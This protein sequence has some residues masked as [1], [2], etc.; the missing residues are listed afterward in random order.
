[1]YKT[2]SW[3]IIKA[4]IFYAVL[5]VGWSFCVSTYVGVV[6][7]IANKELQIMGVSDMTKLGPSLDPNFEVA[8]YHRDAAAM[9]DSLFDFKLESLRSHIPMF[10]ALTFAIPYSF[11]RRLKAAIIGL[12]VLLL[13]DSTVCI[14]I[15]TWSYTFL[16]D[17]HVFT[18][19]SASPVRD[20]IVSFLYNFYNA[21]GVGFIPI[22]VWILA[23]V[24]R[25]DIEKWWKK[26]VKK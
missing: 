18:P 26:E 14:L 16:P 7:P 15:M 22:I 6:T 23:G 4:I 5:I 10:L 1:M 13:I 9:Q 2:I 24:R 25:S 19:F 21:I 20:S 17:Q 8:V 12:I 11:T 3:F